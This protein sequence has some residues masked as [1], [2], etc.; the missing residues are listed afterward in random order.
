MI[1]DTKIELE[2]K[3]A[4]ERFDF[5]ITNKKTIEI[6]EKK[7]KRSISQNSYLHLILSWFAFEYGEKV[8]YVKQEIFKKQVNND[9]FIYQFANKKTGEFRIDWKSTKDLDTKEMTTAIDRFRDFSSIEAGIYLPEPSDLVSLQNIEIELK[10]NGSE[11]Y[12]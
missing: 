5:L 2:S 10:R 3:R 1:Y 7:Q 8:E 11:F 12:I 6:K 4:K 9:I